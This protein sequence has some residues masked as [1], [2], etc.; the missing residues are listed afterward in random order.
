MIGGKIM[1]NCTHPLFIAVDD[2]DCFRLD[3]CVVCEEEFVS[4]E[5]FEFLGK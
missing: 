3:I 1:I 5:D 2:S 4:V